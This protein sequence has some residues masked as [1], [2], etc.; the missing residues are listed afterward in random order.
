VA[1]MLDFSCAE[2]IAAAAA[3]LRCAIFASTRD[4]IASSVMR[5]PC[6]AGGSLS[7]SPPARNSWHDKGGEPGEA[8]VSSGRKCARADLGGG[9]ALGILLVFRIL[10]YEEDLRNWSC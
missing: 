4:L 9:F 1:L 2:A 10:H 7:Q 5:G 6:V 3:A 8:R